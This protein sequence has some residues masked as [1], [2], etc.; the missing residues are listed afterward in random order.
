MDNAPPGF[1]KLHPRRIVRLSSNLPE[2]DPGAG[3]R[4][5]QPPLAIRS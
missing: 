4:R 5:L 3:L 2:A 1:L